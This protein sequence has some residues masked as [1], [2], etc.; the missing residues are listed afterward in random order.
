LYEAPG[1][2]RE[3]CCRTAIDDQNFGGNPWAS[4]SLAV[5]YASAG[6]KSAARNIL[7]HLEREAQHR[8]ISAY[9]IASICA[10]LGDGEKAL[11][12]LGRSLDERS[13][14]NV[15]NDVATDPAFKNLR[16]DPHYANLLH[17]AQPLAE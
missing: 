3:G 6:N 16:S 14:Y 15:G 4:A 12:A 17:R 9:E 5:A 8:Y 1:G 7:D 11:A 10:A 2:T 13:L